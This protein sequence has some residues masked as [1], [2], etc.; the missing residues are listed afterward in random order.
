MRLKYFVGWRLTIWWSLAL[1]RMPGPKPSYIGRCGWLLKPLPMARS[2]FGTQRYEINKE[3]C[4][5]VFWFWVTKNLLD[6]RTCGNHCGDRGAEPRHHG[7]SATRRRR[8]RGGGLPSSWG[9]TRRSCCVFRNWCVF[10]FPRLFT[11]HCLSVVPYFSRLLISLKIHLL[12]SYGKRTGIHLC[13][14]FVRQRGLHR[15]PR[16]IL[17][18]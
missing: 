8:N 15:R 3:N 11:C 14:L 6:S 1:A 10:F 4:R 12:R 18:Q 5:P 9:Y 7:G 13:R 17:A 16:G 2:T